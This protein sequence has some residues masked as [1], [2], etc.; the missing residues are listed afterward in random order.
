MHGYA[1]IIVIPVNMAI[2][3]LIQSVSSVGPA[4]NPRQAQQA[5]HAGLAASRT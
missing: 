3:I 5:S 2:D 4:P 1:Y